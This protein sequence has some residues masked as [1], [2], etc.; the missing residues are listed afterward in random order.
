MASGQDG[1]ITSDQMQQSL[2]IS[3]L[4]AWYW[5]PWAVPFCPVDKAALAVASW[6]RDK[7]T[8]CS[9]SGAGV[10]SNWFTDWFR[11]LFLQLFS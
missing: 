8:E 3:D 10:M 4:N 2:P 7:A 5:K 1:K 9:V 6:L 11:N